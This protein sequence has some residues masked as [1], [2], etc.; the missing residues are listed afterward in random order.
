MLDVKLK[1]VLINTEKTNQEI[2][3]DIQFRIPK[4]TINTILGRNGAG[5][6]TLIK[7]ITQLEDKTNFIVDGKVIFNSLD[8][9]KLD[10]KSLCEIRSKKI[11]YVFQDAA[12][13]FDPLKK[14]SYYFKMVNADRE[15]VELLLA[16]FFLPTS[17]ELEKLYAY[18][19]SGGMAQRISIVLQLLA[20]PELLILDEPT[21]AL[22]LPL[23]NLLMLKLREFTDRKNNSVLMIAQDFILTEKFSDNILVLTGRT[24]KSAASISDANYLLNNVSSHK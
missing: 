2:L 1:S 3:R 12:N 17:V 11:R 14:L 6:S 18:Q 20:E 5:K 22:D 21:S 10:Q 13:L 24:I 23:A 15:K 8:L 9:W 19:L 7:I 4:N 16:E